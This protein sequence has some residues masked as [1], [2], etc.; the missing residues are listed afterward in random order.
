MKP[1]KC[2]EHVWSCESSIEQQNKEMREILL[3]LGA[4][5]HK[6]K[7]LFDWYAENAEGEE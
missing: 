2:C 3:E 7:K 1:C 6:S 5:T 4:E